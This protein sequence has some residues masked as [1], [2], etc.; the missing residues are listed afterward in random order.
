MNLRHRPRMILTAILSQ[1]LALQQ[2]H[3]GIQRTTVLWGN[4]S[5]QGGC[6]LQ[7]RLS[8]S[9]D[10]RGICFQCHPTIVDRAA[11]V[12]LNRFWKYPISPLSGRGGLLGLGPRLV[13]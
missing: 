5:Q 13:A 3:L 9:H 2:Q 11:A 7:H 12:S 10:L 1:S 6:T 4:F 8:V